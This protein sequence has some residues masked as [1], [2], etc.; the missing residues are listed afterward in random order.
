MSYSTATL[1]A[2]LAAAV[3]TFALQS[4]ALGAV[5]FETIQHPAFVGLG[6]GP[7]GFVGTDDDV[8]DPTNTA[9]AV[10]YGIP[11]AGL[12]LLYSESTT[13]INEPFVFENGT[14]TVTDF[15]T[16]GSVGGSSFVD[17][18]PP[19]GA[20]PHEMLTDLQGRTDGEYYL[21]FEGQSCELPDITRLS[22]A[23][24]F[25]QSNR[26]L[27]FFL[28]RGEDPY[29]LPGI[30]PALASYLD[31]LTGVVP[32][33]WTAIT[34]RAAGRLECADWDPEEFGFLASTEE[35]TLAFYDLL[36]P[37]DLGLPFGSP[38]NQFPNGRPNPRS[39]IYRNLEAV[40]QYNSY[41]NQD[42]IN[43]TV[44]D[45]ERV[46][47][48]RSFF[49]ISPDYVCLFDNPGAVI[50]Q[51]GV[52]DRVGRGS[53]PLGPPGTF[54]PQLNVVL[55]VTGGVVATVSTSPI[56]FIVRPVPIA[57]DIKPDSDINP[58]NP[59]SQGVIPVAILGSPDFDVADI[60]VTTLA[61]GPGGAA[62]AH[63]QGG[64]FED[65][66]D[67][68]LPEEPTLKRVDFSGTSIYPYSEGTVTGTFGVYD[69]PPG[70]SLVP[71][72][73]SNV[74]F[75]AT[76]FSE[77]N[78]SFTGW[79][80]VYG[81]VYLDFTNEPPE[82]VS[83]SLDPFS[84]PDA[85]IE[86]NQLLWHLHTSSFGPG[87]VRPS[88]GNPIDSFHLY[89]RQFGTIDS[90]PLML[91]TTAVPAPAPGRIL[92]SH[93]RTQETGIAHGNTELCV[94]GEL[95]DGT[96]FE[97]CDAIWTVPGCGLGFELVLLL[98]PLVWARLW[99][100]RRLDDVDAE[101]PPVAPFDGR[102]WD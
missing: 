82:L 46:G 88:S 26:G 28:R 9:G 77:S 52:A 76:G 79:K 12:L 97:G 54:L 11:P 17:F 25:A 47:L 56:E 20:I 68:G 72:V 30:D 34:I 70:T 55:P 83:T 31:H 102:G 3:A 66:S 74:E 99:R 33:D 92:L 81:S 24:I 23:R 41:P 80:N 53:E 4:Q 98:P 43:T 36:D 40:E 62:P 13:T 90:G 60:D 16:S 29:A 89:H 1:Q 49:R 85:Y 95:F 57:I 19:G 51:R 7:D 96:T 45:G 91:T 14:S 100:R 61:F 32:A 44:V 71:M 18:A 21:C 73:A 48:Q 22:A 63:T 39:Y 87:G 2:A 69:V 58:I 75:V 101:A 15:T 65:T 38:S 5:V 8:Q 27:G 94:T 42:N 78:G 37:F 35:E 50:T 86:D 67:D 6:P 59:S 93:Y 84:V 10:T 64:H